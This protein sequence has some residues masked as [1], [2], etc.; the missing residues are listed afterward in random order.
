MCTPTMLTEEWQPLPV[1]CL[2][3]KHIV[4]L[5][6]R[7]FHVTCCTPARRGGD[8]WTLE[9]RGACKDDL[10]DLLSVT[11]DRNQKVYAKILQE[12]E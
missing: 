7:E 11:V 5:V 6:G 2:T 4:S 1:R 8:F 9:A 12:G 3:S 10:E